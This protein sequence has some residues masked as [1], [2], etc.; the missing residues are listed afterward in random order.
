MDADSD[1]PPITGQMAT[2]WCYPS[3]ILPLSLRTR[4]AALSTAFNWIFTFVVVEVTPVG[5]QNLGRFYYLIY[6]LFVSILDWRRKGLHFIDGLSRRTLPWSRSSGTRFQRLARYRWR[7]P[8]RYSTVMHLRQPSMAT[9]QST[10]HG[11]PPSRRRFAFTKTF[12][13]DSSSKTRGW[14][15][16]RL[17][18]GQTGRKTNPL[19]WCTKRQVVQALWLKKI[20]VGIRS[21]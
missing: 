6:A 2:V 10:Q 4:G 8:T 21:R 1:S 11:V 5:V 15:T 3:E 19:T 9:G 13:V 17:C 14:K 18:V 12:V 16:W 7:P 20:V